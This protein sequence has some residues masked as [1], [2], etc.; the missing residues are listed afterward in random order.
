MRPTNPE[1]PGAP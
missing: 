1:S